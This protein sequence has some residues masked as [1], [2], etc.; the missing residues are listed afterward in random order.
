[1][2][3]FARFFNLLYK[4]IVRYEKLKIKKKGRKKGKTCE[5]EKNS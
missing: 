3:K 5:D 2:L 4:N 1:M